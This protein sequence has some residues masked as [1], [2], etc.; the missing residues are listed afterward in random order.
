M[1]QELQQIY[2]YSGVYLQP[3]HLQSVDLHHSYMLSQHRR[4][5][6]PWNT[7][8]IHCDFNPETL[9]DFTLK[10][11]R[12]QAIL[13]SGDYLEFPGNCILTPR[14][15]R[16]AWKQPEKPFMLWLAL[17]R[18]DPAHANVGDTPNSRWLKPQEEGVMK[19]V[20]FSGPECSVARIIYN[21]Q[22]LSEE[23]KNAV[24]DCEFLPLVRLRYENDRVIPD[25]DFCP[26]LVML[27]SSPPLKNLLEGLYAELANR[28]HQFAE[29]KRPDQLKSASRSDMT[30]LMAMRSLN[31]MLPL[32][33]QYSQTPVMHPWPVYGLLAQLVGELSSFSDQCTFNGEWADG[34]TALLPYDHF[35][36][37]AC[38]SSAKKIL[39]ALLNNLSLEDNTWVKLNPDDQQIFRGNLQSLDW[40]KDKTV[41]LLLRSE[42]MASADNVQLADFKVA[43]DTTVTTLIQHA[44]PGVTATLLNPAPRGVPHRKDAFYFTLNQQDDLWKHIEQKQ[45]IAFYWSDAPTDLQVQVIFMGSA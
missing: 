9:V 23:E 39:I 27:N 34:E 28:A 29:Y 30:Q 13:P 17:R 26:P 1:Y 12:L 14:Q 33:G 42:T 21:V 11:E 31:R 22:I 41:L 43:T 8:I 20:Y 3:Q 6:Q 15:F 5:A 45:N 36:L 32:L 37:H 44:L 35:N 38:F 4:L 19:D 24:V 18:F 25:P 7:G 40:K 2:W 16:D 10:I